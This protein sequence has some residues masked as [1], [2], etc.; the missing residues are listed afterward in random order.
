MVNLTQLDKVNTVSN[1]VEK[2]INSIKVDMQTS[3]VNI[4]SRESANSV[5][6]SRSLL[7]AIS[8]K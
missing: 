8:N 5:D 2:I 4:N 7:M 6:N 1:Q 3:G